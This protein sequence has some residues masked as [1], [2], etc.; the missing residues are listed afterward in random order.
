MQVELFKPS[1]MNTDFWNAYRQMRDASAVY[2]DPFFDPEFAKIVGSL[3][4][5]TFIAVAFD[6]AKQ[7]PLAFWPL[8]VRPG[9]WTRP[10]GGPFSDWHGPIVHPSDPVDPSL[11]LAKAGLAGFTAFGIPGSLSWG[12][13]S[14]RVGANM[15]DVSEGWEKYLATQTKMYPKHF[16]KIR[17]MQRNMERDFSSVEYVLNDTSQESYDWLIERKRDQFVR[18][19]RHDVLGVEW[20][21]KLLDTLRSHHSDRLSAQLMTL[22]LDGKIAAAEF[23]LI[24]DNVIHGWITAFDTEH[25]YYSPGYMLQHE[26]IKNMSDMGRTIYDSGIGLDY[27][28]KYY[29]NF[30]LP[31]DMGVIRAE[32]RSRFPRLLAEGWRATETSMP[33]VIGNVMGKIRRRTDQ[34]VLTETTVGGRLSGF[35]KALKR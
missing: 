35:A 29:T 11:Y 27:Y 13:T 22:K 28:K 9:G 23:N 34:I 12:Q 10:V 8:H 1:E 15:T 24:S 17:R 32:P 26:V 19:G 6:Q 3:R 31:V 7:D 30:Q 18:T 16:K 4:S 21:R 20:T 33:G 2:D 5:D 25:S 14:E